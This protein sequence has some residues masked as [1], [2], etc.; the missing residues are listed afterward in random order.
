MLALRLITASSERPTQPAQ[1]PRRQRAR[2]PRAHRVLLVWAAVEAELVSVRG[3]GSSVGS[4]AASHSN[5]EVSRAALSHVHSQVVTLE[6]ELESRQ[7]Q[8][9]SDLEAL[10]M[11][12]A[13]AAESRRMLKSAQAWVASLDEMRLADLRTIAKLEAQL[14]QWQLWHSAKT[15]GPPREGTPAAPPSVGC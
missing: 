12:Q 11:A 14:R 8:H 1:R 15:N 5:D 4:G 7:S 10:C 9:Q 2:P 6:R 13:D 3:H